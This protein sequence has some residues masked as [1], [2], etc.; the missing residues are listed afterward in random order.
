MAATRERWRKGGKRLFA[1]SRESTCA[2]S[3]AGSVAGTSHQN[4][5]DIKLERQSVI[6]N[7]CLDDIDVKPVEP[8]IMAL[9]G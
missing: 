8:D 6:Q 1:S 9:A 5:S 4:H 3:V 2:R 7:F